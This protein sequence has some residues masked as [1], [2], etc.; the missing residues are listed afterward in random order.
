MQ[1]EKRPDDPVEACRQFWSVL[2]ELFVADPATHSNINWERCD[3]PNERNF[4][5]YWGEIIFPSIQSVHL[6]AEQLVGMTSPVLIIHGE[7]DRS[8]PYGGAR[9]WAMMWPNARLL[10]V[11]D[12]AHAPWI[13]APEI[14]LPAIGEF[15]DGR[16]PDRAEK[17]KASSGG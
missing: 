4:A 3:L 11:P 5:K 15:L 1:Q 2:R 17:I 7:R 10:T 9:D 14:V 6:T 13:E 8:A 12:T 16:W